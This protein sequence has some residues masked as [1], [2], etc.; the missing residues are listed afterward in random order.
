MHAE[1][2]ARKGAH[3]PTLSLA[4]RDRRWRRTRELMRRENL[5]GLLVAGFRAREMYESYLADDYNE[6]CVLF[7]LEGD[8]VVVTWAALRVKRA[9]YSVEQGHQLWIEDYR[10]AAS[11][12]AVAQVVQEMGLAQ[13]RLGI[14]GLR[15]VAPT[16]QYGSIPAAFW[17][18][19]SAALPRL[20][21]RDFSE[22]FS[23]LMLV[24]S[25]EELAQMRYA[26]AAAEA[27][28][29]V[30]ADI[31]DA[32]VGEEEI[33]A[34]A[35][36]EMLRHGIGLRYP[37]IVMNSGPHTLS[38]GPPRW[39]T[40]GEAPRTLQRGDLLQA[41]LMPLCGNQE[42]QVQMTVALDPVD[43]L[44]L[45]CERIARASYDAGIAALKPGI[46]FAELLAAMEEP[47]KTA[48][49]WG[50]TPLVH[51][52]APHFLAGSTLVNREKVNL[53]VRLA[54]PP[55]AVNRQRVI[56]A[57]MVFAFEPN[58]CLG[59]HRVNIGGTVVVTPGGCEPLNDIPTRVT[60]K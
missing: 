15:S 19:F 52:V 24:K 37:M 27:G 55:R 6:G 30:I 3:P 23:H 5:D 18:D 28:C 9:Q 26:A 13:A 22:E 12:T 54:G 34:E 14:V 43:D 36:A 8:P 41:E 33:F 11:G 38:W 46:A 32:G 45:K 7:P 42:A 16:E 20:Q 59:Q 25:E 29:R 35:T 58:A 4:E 53:G 17:M 2:R 1:R 50:Y 10:V 21:H 44:S 51:S 57:G 47:L 31:A 60:H 40:R 49:C 48:G 56:E 39:T